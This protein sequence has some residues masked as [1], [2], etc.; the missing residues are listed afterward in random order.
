MRTE[1]YHIEARGGGSSK[2][3]KITRDMGE[4]EAGRELAGFRAGNQNHGLGNEFRL[5]R[6]ITLVEIEV[7]T[8]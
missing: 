7:L 8:D 6:K 2:W 1:S 4:Q 5:I 3:Q